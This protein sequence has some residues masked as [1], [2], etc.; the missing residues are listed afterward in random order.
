MVRR[1]TK[2]R[3]SPEACRR[4]TAH[5]NT[6]R[7]ACGLTP[8]PVRSH[9][10]CIAL[11]ASIPPGVSTGLEARTVPA[12][13]QPRSTSVHG[14]TPG[15]ARAP[16]DLG[17]QGF[18]FLGCLSPSGPLLLNASATAM[19]RAGTLRLHEAGAGFLGAFTT[20]AGRPSGSGPNGHCDRRSRKPRR[21]VHHIA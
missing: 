3:A 6:R 19:T 15:D 16:S 14:R 21:K 4:A 18:P 2:R 12:D 20:P 10:P 1:R 5:R 13:Q 8:R 7:G 17:R 11:A 9:P